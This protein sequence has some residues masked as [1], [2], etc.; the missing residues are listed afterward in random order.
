MGEFGKWGLTALQNV[1][2]TLVWEGLWDASLEYL[3]GYF[4]ER[5]VGLF[6]VASPF[7]VEGMEPLER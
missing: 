5:V 6:L 7:R 1:E 2:C 4:G 3:E